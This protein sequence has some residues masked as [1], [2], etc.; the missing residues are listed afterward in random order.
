MSKSNS[1]PPVRPLRGKTIDDEDDTVLMVYAR[2]EDDFDPDDPGPLLEASAEPARA[3]SRKHTSA[4]SR[5]L[6]P[7]ETS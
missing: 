5:T 2:P 7:S 4:T 1:L 6:R 3:R